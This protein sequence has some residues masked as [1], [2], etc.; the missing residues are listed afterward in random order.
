M[1]KRKSITKL[2]SDEQYHSPL[3]AQM[4]TLLH[5]LKSHGA[6]VP[7]PNKP[8]QR[9]AHV[10]TTMKSKN[11]WPMEITNPEV[12]IL[13]EAQILAYQIENVSYPTFTPA[14]AVAALLAQKLVEAQR[15]ADKALYEATRAKQLNEKLAAENA[16]LKRRLVA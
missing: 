16:Q 12:R 6:Q 9:A 13:S 7:E 10:L 15:V 3:T 8:T 4:D 1:A 11:R 14:G 2:S 5:W